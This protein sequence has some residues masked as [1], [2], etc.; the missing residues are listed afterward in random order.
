[1]ADSPAGAAPPSSPFYGRVIASIA[2]EPVQQPILPEQIRLAVP[3]HAGDRLNELALSQ[4][5]ERLYATGRYEHVDVNGELSG[6]GVALTFRTRPRYFLSRIAVEGVPAPPT[7][8]QLASSS[9]LSLGE[10]F[11]DETVPEATRKMQALLRA[12]GFFA[13]TVE[14]KSSTSEPTE[15]VE[16][17]F[18]VK[19]GRRARFTAPVLAGDL[20]FDSGRILRA[21]GWQSLFGW[22]GWRELTD[23]R[24]QHGVE[25]VRA[26]YTRKGYLTSSVRLNALDYLAAANTVAPRLVIAPGPRVDI[27]IEGAHVSTGTLKRVLPILQE[28][29]IDNELLTEGVR[30]LREYFVG[31]GYFDASVAYEERASDDAAR[32]NVVYR[33]VHGPRSRFTRLE[34][35][36]AKY[37]DLATIRERMSLVPASFARSR[38]GIFSPVLLQ[39]DIDALQQIYHSNG[40]RE[41]KVTSD[42]IRGDRGK[43]QNVAVSIRIEEGRQTFVGNLKISGVDLHLFDDIMAVVSSKTGQPFSISN[44]A[45][46]RDAILGYYFNNGYPDA[47]FDAQIEPEQDDG[48]VN[49]KYS[50]SEGRRLFTR[51]VLLNGLSTTRQSLVDRRM[52]IQP[53]QPLS[54]GAIVETQRRL[55]DLGIFSAVDVAV[56]NPDGIERSKYVVLQLD[57]ARRYTLNFGLG[58]EIGGFGGSATNFDQ[59]AGGAGFSPRALIGISRANMFGIGHTAAITGRVSTIQQRVLASYLAPQ[60]KGDDNLSLS[61]TTLFDHSSDIR[62]FTSQ[63]LEGSAALSQKLSR[64]GLLQYRIA[65]RQVSIDASTLRISPA[66]IPVYSVAVRTTILAATWI[67]DRRDDPLESTRGFYSTVDFGVAPSIIASG[68]YYTRLVVKNSS[69][70]RL[71]KDIILARTA[72]LGW[73]ENL[74]NKPV[75]LP[76]RFFGGG[77]TTNRAFPENQ[78]GPRDPITGFPLGGNAFLFVGTE[79]RFPVLGKT[80]GGVLF[81]D[82]GNVYSEL[83]SISFR[84][85]QRDNKDFN[86]MV[87]SA[88]IGIRYRTPIGPIRVDVGYSPNA[89]RFM[90]YSGTRDQLLAGTSPQF[91]VPQRVNPFQF[92]FSLG[93]TF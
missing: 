45:I 90:G 35:N 19:P 79:V 73:L 34:V 2:F 24:L 28:R 3:F 71:G 64:S 65:L 51:G 83:H 52:S 85:N 93:Q 11:D 10:V 32:R 92:F 60:F 4:A 63:R 20:R 16:L 23:A 30:S 89:P 74:S 12:N 57:E 22:R 84:F 53:G 88:G 87:H 49:L 18:T 38:R 1:M 40:F 29:S 47:T 7:R 54:Q 44:V 48:R 66:L 46:D 14:Y 91:T 31:E 76:E 55:H 6:E 61:F 26:L 36:G 62:T 27:R 70:H 8:E 86:Y 81:H 41:V 25:H 39:H 69:Y 13:A 78:A 5:I 58:A 75:P 42:V 77:N 33:V 68:T 80:L 17:T 67:Q 37:F 82:M 59:P 15:E 56:Q 72:S 50:V 21:T 43:P 9:A